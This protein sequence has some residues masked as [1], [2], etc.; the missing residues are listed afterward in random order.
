[1]PPGMSAAPEASSAPKPSPPKETKREEPKE[2][3]MEVDDEDAQAK[4]A[5][6]AL[7][8][9]G[10]ALY[11][12]RNF[13]EA[14]QKY[15]RAWET[16][17]KDV[18]YLT[19]LSAVYF[20]K[21]DYEKCIET[22]EK[23]V[24]EGRELRCDYKTI[25]K[26]LGRIGNAYNKLGDLDNAIKYYSKSLT[27]HRTP[28]ILTKLRE[29]EKA[30]AQAAKEAYIDPAKAEAAREE[31]NT[32]FKAGDYAT[33]VK[34][35]TEAIKRAPTDPRGYTNRS[36]AYTK[37]LALPEALRD[38]DEAIKQDPKFIKAYIRKG[39]VQQGM[40]EHTSA[41]A[42]LQKASELDTEKKHQHELES[43][44][45]K[46]MMELQT[47]RSGESEE[48]TY[49]RAMRDPEV[50]EIMNDPV[51]R[52]ILSDAQQNPRALQDHMKNP[53]ISQKSE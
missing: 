19:N 49:A 29:A 39:L 8:T 2:E 51:M 27:E 13:D 52:Q 31:G 14:I 24:E 9:E 17:P 7:K 40:K 32:A 1:M 47:Q 43:N 41:L 22:A 15:E 28:D 44:M 34:H 36:A 11:K 3:P 33:A 25:A 16:Y 20:E 53:M 48:E 42:T 45:T 6:D 10:N 4:K 21:G 37:L 35:Y 50:A 12:A 23:A 26:A 5:A 18:A 38:A 46:I 30:Q